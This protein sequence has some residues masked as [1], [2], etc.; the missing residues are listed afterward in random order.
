MSFTEPS[1]G[2]NLKMRE[3]FSILTQGIELLQYETDVVTGRTTI[4]S[5][6]MWIE[7]DIYRMC[8]DSIR[9]SI[10]QRVAG[11]IPAGLYLR[12]ISEIRDGIKAFPFS[13]PDATPQDEGC[14][15]SLIGSERCLSLEFPSNFARDW[16]SARFRLV[17]ED[18]LVEEERQQR[19]YKIWENFS[20]LSD[21]QLGQVTRLQG[22]LERG[23]EVT[24]HWRSGEKSQVLLVYDAP[25]KFLSINRTITTHLMYTQEVTLKM[26]VDDIAE[27]KLGAQSMSFV[28]SDSTSSQSALSLVASQNNFDFEFASQVT[29]DVF[30][31]QV[32]YA[33]CI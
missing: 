28:R 1:K 17:S 27:I 30:G 23:I 31:E 24:S 32:H 3:I 26:Q 21:E 11:I 13:N 18:I 6:S 20:P 33:D 14:C 22:L 15:L 8:C 19:T 29:R 10:A 7:T 16:F 4:S 12:D 9:P 2:N 25:G 5:K